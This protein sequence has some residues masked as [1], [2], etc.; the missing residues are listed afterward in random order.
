M[1]PAIGFVLDASEIVTGEAG[2]GSAVGVGSVP[3]ARV[4][5][6]RHAWLWSDWTWRLLG[7]AWR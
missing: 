6:R 5:R 1:D 3:C 7:R 2:I 4:Q